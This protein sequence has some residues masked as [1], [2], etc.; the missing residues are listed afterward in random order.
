[1]NTTDR[2][3]AHPIA[4]PGEGTIAVR[5][6]AGLGLQPS[7]LDDWHFRR[8]AIVYVRQFDP[9]QVLNHIESRER[10]YALVNLAVALGWPKDRILLIGR[11]PR[12]QWQNGRL[13]NRIS[14]PLGRSYHGSCRFDPGDQDEPRGPE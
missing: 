4:T 2:S 12:Q 8:L 11:G 10:Q 7:P 9:Q 14:S 5:V 13:A 1:M 6:A 3:K